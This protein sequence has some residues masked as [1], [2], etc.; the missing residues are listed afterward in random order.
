MKGIGS[1]EF[2]KYPEQYYWSAFTRNIGYY[3]SNGYVVFVPDIYYK[4]GHARQIYIRLCGSGVK[5]LVKR[6]V[7]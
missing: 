1:L 6:R 3:A 4:I 2:P 5:E 7:G